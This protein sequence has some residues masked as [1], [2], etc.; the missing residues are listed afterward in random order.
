MTTGTSNEFRTAFDV[1]IKNYPVSSLEKMNEKK[2]VMRL[3]DDIH[4]KFLDK[5]TVFTPFSSIFTS[6]EY[7]CVTSNMLF[8][9]VFNE[10]G[11]PYEIRETPNHV[12]LVAYPNSS[13]ITVE[14]TCALPSSG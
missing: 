13:Y 2:K 3:Y 12:F 5:Y 8:A 7:H 4:E 1:F 9:L 6:Q 14:T 11:I 10:F